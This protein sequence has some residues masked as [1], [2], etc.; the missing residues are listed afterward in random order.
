MAHYS[1]YTLNEV[2]SSRISLPRIFALLGSLTL[3]I[4]RL[5]PDKKQVLAEP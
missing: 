1:P 3:V 2:N 4:K 5:T